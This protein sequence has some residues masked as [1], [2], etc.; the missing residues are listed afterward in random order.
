MPNGTEINRVCPRYPNWLDAFALFTAPI[1]WL[2][3]NKFIF[4]MLQGNQIQGS[5]K[6]HEKNVGVFQI[7]MGILF[8]QEKQRLDIKE[9][10]QK[11]Q[12]QS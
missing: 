6:K 2:K 7:F 12:L 4:N 3:A 10:K 1:F 9:H 8:Q 11:I 5:K